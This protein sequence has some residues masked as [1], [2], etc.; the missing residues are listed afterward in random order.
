MQRDTHVNPPSTS[1]NPLKDAI[2]VTSVDYS[3]QFDGLVKKADNLQNFL[4][5]GNA[6]SGLLGYLPGLAK[7]LY[8]GQIKGTIEKKSYADDTYKDLK[9]AEFNIQLSSNQYMNFHNLHLVFPLKIKKGTNEANNIDATVITINNFF[10]HWIKEIDIKKLG[11]DAPILPTTNTVEIYKY[12]DALLKHIPKKALAVIENDLLCSKKKVVLPDGE[13]RRKR[14][15]AAGGDATERTDDNLD[16]RIQK[17]ANQLKTT[18]YYRIPLKYICNLGFVN[19]PIKFN[20]KWRLTF[21]SDM[22]RLFESKTNLDVGAAYPN[23]VDAKIILNSA[24]YLLY[25]QFSLEDTY[26]SYLEGAMVSAQVLI[27]GLKFSPYQ[28]S[29]ELVAGS[30]SKTFTFTNAFKQF[31]FLEFSLVLDKSDQHLNIYDSY[32]AETAAKS[33]KYIKLQNASNTYS[34]FNTIKFNL[35]DEEDR[36]VLYNAFVVWVTKGSSIAPESD[37]LY[38][39][40][41][42]ELPTRKN[43]FTNSDERVYIDI[44]RSKGY[45]GEFERVNRDDSDLVVTVDLKNAAGKKM[46][47]YVT[48]Y[49]QGEYMYMLTKDGLIMNHKEY[50][51]A[52]IKNKT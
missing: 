20:T 2:S 33:I 4:E 41:R 42:Q 44:R 40:V 1:L 16:E 21:E 13:D 48:G 23:S 45:T 49:Y 34:E 27:T 38:N 28:K 12:S 7:P 5:K 31:A 43:Y 14:H 25:H 50:S 9:T 17:F 10:T 24:P 51:I 3:T 47:L 35:E 36:Y 22:Q 18:Y 39:E 37:F 29:Y 19:T 30:Q 46:R 32:N 11:D 26:R 15:T 6:E 8:Q 52:K